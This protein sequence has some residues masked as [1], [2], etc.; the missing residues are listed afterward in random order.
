MQRDHSLPKAKQTIID[1]DIEKFLFKG[2][3]G[4]SL[5]EGS[6][7]ISPIIIQP[8]RDSSHRDNLI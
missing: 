3:A 1:D 6:Q 2:I 8:K 7:L 4:L 5:H